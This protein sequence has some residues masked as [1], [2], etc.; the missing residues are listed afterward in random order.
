MGDILYNVNNELT[1]HQ[2]RLQLTY[3]KRIA[4]S[5][6]LS[7]IAGAEIKDLKN[8]TNSSTLYGYSSDGS[9]VASS[10]DFVS[11]F[12][13][14]QYGPNAQFV[15]SQIP[16]STSVGESVDRFVSYFGNI[17]YNYDARYSFSISARQDAA[18]LF[19]VKTNQKGVP[20]WS[21]GGGWEIS[22][23]SFYKVNPIPYLKLRASY[24]HNGNFSRL[25][26]ALTTIA[27]RPNLNFLGAPQAYIVN[28]PNENLRW[29]QVRIL[30]IGLDFGTKN[31]RVTGTFE[32][33]KKNIRDLMSQGPIDPTTG[34]TP[35]NGG[36]SY[37]YG[38]IASMKGHGFD[39]QIESRNLTGKFKWNTNFLYSYALN[40]VSEYYL[41]KP[42]TSSG[43]IGL[44]SNISP[45]VGK[46][47]YVMYSYPWAGLDELGDPMGYLGKDKTKNYSAILNSTSID[48]IVYHGPVQPPPFRSLTKYF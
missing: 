17:L 29:E 16:N 13:Q 15:E 40:K 48:S 35:V 14:F 31:D 39:L 47:L 12:P 25:A 7:A 9:R 37:F 26:S 6:K 28:P 41:P 23:E 27:Y 10:M 2:G 34:L 36:I 19:G 32:Y 3:E 46:P 22:N 33:W 30:N 5:H 38:N 20:L 18:N 21:V 24:G 43:Y 4:L 42:T 1:S 8:T 11:F 45:I 44:E